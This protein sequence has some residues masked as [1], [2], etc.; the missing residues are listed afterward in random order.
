MQLE[1]V[2]GFKQVFYSVFLQAY[3]A[4]EIWFLGYRAMQTMHY[5]FLFIF[6]DKQIVED[7]FVTNAAIVRGFIF[8][9]SVKS[10]RNTFAVHKSQRLKNLT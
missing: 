2:V 3:E 1:V 8:T 6:F 9:A 4:F 5:I 10:D 7:F